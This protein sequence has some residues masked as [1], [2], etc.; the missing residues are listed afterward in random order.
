MV[1]IRG[2]VRNSVAAKYQSRKVHTPKLME[3]REGG[4][5]GQSTGGQ[6]KFNLLIM[7]SKRSKGQYNFYD[8][9]VFRPFGR[10]F[11][12]KLF[13]LSLFFYYGNGTIKDVV[14]NCVQHRRHTGQGKGWTR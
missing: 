5:E 7:N 3:E 11:L 6:S 2:E 12:A 4:R 9:H 14:F 13:L 10:R 8:N 1:L